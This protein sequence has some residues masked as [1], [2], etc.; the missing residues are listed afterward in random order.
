MRKLIVL[1]A[2]ALLGLLS[3]PRSAAAQSGFVVIVNDG[4]AARSLSRDEL[5]QIFLKQRTD[6]PSGL[7]ALPVDLSDGSPVREAFSQS[8]HGRSNSAVD[9]FWQR[10]IFSGRGVPPLQ[11]S[12][13]DEVIAFVRGNAG[14][15]GYVSRG[16]SLG[17]GV[18]AVQVVDR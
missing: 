12:S 11:K 13:D 5:S 18:H 4:N 10:Q 1:V 3:G 2:V 7:A 9:A 15:V 8:V 16:A 14:A 17:G 6:F